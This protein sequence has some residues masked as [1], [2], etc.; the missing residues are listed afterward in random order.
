M[1][2]AKEDESVFGVELCTGGL[3]SLMFGDISSAER[4]VLL[5][6]IASSFILARP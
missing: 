2:K 5:S 1:S 4:S 6:A 3:M